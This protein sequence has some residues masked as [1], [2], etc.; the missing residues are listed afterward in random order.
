MFRRGDPDFKVLV[1]RTLAR[2]MRSGEMEKIHAKWFGPLG[3]PV[4]EMTRAA[5]ALQALP[6]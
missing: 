2:L 6:E 1:A 3:I 4:D 5:F